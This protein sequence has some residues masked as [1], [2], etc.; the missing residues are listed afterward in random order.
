MH[1]LSYRGVSGL[2]PYGTP[3]CERLSRPWQAHAAQRSSPLFARSPR[4]TWVSLRTARQVVKP[5][6]EELRAPPAH[7]DH[8]SGAGTRDA[9][10]PHPQ[11]WCARAHTHKHPCTEMPAVGSHATGAGALPSCSPPDPSSLSTQFQ[12]VENCQPSN[13]TNLGLVFRSP[14][15]LRV[16][17]DLM[18]NISGTRR[19]PDMRFCVCGSPSEDLSHIASLMIGCSR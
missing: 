6:V 2:T 15:T 12:T 11:L 16:F 14:R 1:R 19:R 7:K 3:L 9:G 10:R 18:S 5:N 13:P 8:Q 17:G 4:S